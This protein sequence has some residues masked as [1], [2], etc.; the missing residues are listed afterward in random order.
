MGEV[1]FHLIGTK[2]IQVRAANETLTAAAS[3]FQNLKSLYLLHRIEIHVN[4]FSC[5]EWDFLFL[6]PVKCSITLNRYV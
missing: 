5:H 2:S 3:N 1:S 6:V 4:F